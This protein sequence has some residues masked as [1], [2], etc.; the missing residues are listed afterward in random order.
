MQPRVSTGSRA[1]RLRAL[2]TVLVVLCL[3]MLATSVVSVMVALND[4]EEKV[5]QVTCRW[6][7]RSDAVELVARTDVGEPGAPAS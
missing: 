6:C 4:R 5:E 7:G 2:V 1:P 3:L